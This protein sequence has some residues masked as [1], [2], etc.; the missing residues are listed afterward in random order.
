MAEPVLQSL[1]LEGLQSGDKR[2]VMGVTIFTIANRCSVRGK[3]SR[4]QS[5]S[6]QRFPLIGRQNRISRG[7]CKLR[8]AR[9]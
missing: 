7:P 9:R 4:S 8:R 6:P 2:A 1:P 5:A 3:Q